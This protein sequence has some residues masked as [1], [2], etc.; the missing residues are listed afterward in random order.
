[1]AQDNMY[2]KTQTQSNMSPI[3]KARPV[4]ETVLLRSEEDEKKSTS[5]SNSAAAA[6]ARKAAAG[7]IVGPGIRRRRFF[8]DKNSRIL[9]K[10]EVAHKLGHSFSPA[11]KWLIMTVIAALQISMNMNA[12]IFGNC[13]HELELVFGVAATVATLCQAL[14]LIA[15]AFGCELWAP[16][17]EESGRWIT[18]QLSLGLVNLWQIPPFVLT[19]F[20]APMSGRTVGAVILLCR[21]L[22][23]LCSAGGSV[24]LGMIAD[25][26]S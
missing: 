2:H 21:I 11:R 3:D 4:F 20:A 16:W 23:G 19:L 7:G 17:S 8:P 9:H 14:F 6:A 24:T 10:K 15:Y 1:M 5:R 26:V 25:M 13:V 12:S 18:L 22:G